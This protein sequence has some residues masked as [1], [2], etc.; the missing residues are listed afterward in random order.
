MAS[1]FDYNRAS[2]QAKAMGEQVTQSM[3]QATDQMRQQ[4]E[5][6]LKQ[7][8]EAMAQVAERSRDAMDR[9]MK[10]FDDFGMT[11]RGNA[12]A[13]LAASRAAAQGLE[14]IV[15]QAAEFSRKTFEG[16]TSAMRTM[17]AAKTP[18]DV[19]QAQSEF[20][21]TQFDTLVGEFSKLSETMMR[22]TNDVFEPL[23]S[24]MSETAHKAGEAMKQGMTPP[25]M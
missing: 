7:S 20:A 14:Q 9:G 8:Q 25:K 15:Q 1:N 22:V 21:R 5:A 23:S 3:A 13:W 17:A 4:G 2:E 16:A 19:M 11:A 24:R 18:A 6:A 10:A 12:D